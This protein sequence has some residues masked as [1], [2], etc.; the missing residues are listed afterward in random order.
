M[1]TRILILGAAGEIG[2]LMTDLLLKQTDASLVLY[3]RNAHSRLKVTDKDRITLVDGDFNEENKLTKA[4]KD[5]TIVYVNH[6]ADKEAIQAIASAMKSSGIT[7]VIAATI[8]GIYDEVPGAFGN[9]NKQ[10]VGAR[11]IHEVAEATKLF[12][13]QFFDYTLLRLTWLY[14]ENGNTSYMLTQKGQPFIGAQVTRQ[15]VAKLILDIVT[16]EDS[17]FVKQSLGVSEPDTNWDK[18]SF[19]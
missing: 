17:R 1:K 14:N 5:V 15:A 16:S 6:M 13:N 12:E 18:P 8:L 19:Y 2:R 4:M 9:W 10:M 3:A 7:R 11:R